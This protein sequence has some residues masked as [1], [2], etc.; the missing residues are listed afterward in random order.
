MMALDI[1]ISRAG[2]QSSPVLVRLEKTVDR[3]AYPALLS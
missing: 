2:G 3:G 1:F